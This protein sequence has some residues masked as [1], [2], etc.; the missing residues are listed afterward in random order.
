[1]DFKFEHLKPFELVGSGDP[2]AIGGAVTVALCG[3]WE[4]PPPCRWPHRTDV[5]H[6]ERTLIARVRFSCA[7]HDE[8]EV[9]HRIDSALASGELSGPDGTQTRWRPA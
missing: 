4:H 3:H 6:G 7:D 5:V 2:A 8:Q 1:M 9:R